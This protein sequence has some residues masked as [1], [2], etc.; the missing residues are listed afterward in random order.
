MAINIIKIALPAIIRESDQKK[1]TYVGHGPTRI[2][3]PLDIVPF[4]AS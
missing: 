3:S 2:R 1:Y 4:V